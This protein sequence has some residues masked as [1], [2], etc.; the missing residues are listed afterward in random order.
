MA[1]VK[2]QEAFVSWVAQK[3]NL[4]DG[5]VQEKNMCELFKK[6]AKIPYNIIHHG[7]KAFLK[8][9]NSDTSNGHQINLFLVHLTLLS[10]NLMAGC[11]TGILKNK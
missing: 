5:V 11:Q 6:K 9:S 3:R 2:G 8:C 4:H 10:A 7:E 1:A